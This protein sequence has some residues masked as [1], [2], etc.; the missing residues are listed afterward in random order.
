[1]TSSWLPSQRL[2]SSTHRVLRD[3]RQSQTGSHGLHLKLRIAWQRVGFV[4]LGEKE[5]KCQ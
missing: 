3:A 5:T 1:M 4:L 2:L